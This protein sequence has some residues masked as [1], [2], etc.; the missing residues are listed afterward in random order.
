MANTFD[1]NLV[2]DVAN[3]AMLNAFAG[4]LPSTELFTTDVSA[5]GVGGHISKVAPSDDSALTEVVDGHEFGR[6]DSTLTPVTVPVKYWEKGGYITPAQIN[7]GFRIEDIIQQKADAM[8][9]GINALIT[10]EITPANFPSNGLVAATRDALSVDDV[11]E[12]EGNIEAGSKALLL[13]P[14]YYSKFTPTSTQSIGLDEG[15]YGYDKGLHKCSKFADASVV[16]FAGSKS[17]LVLATG[18]PAGSGMADRNEKVIEMPNGVEVLFATWQELNTGN[19]HFSF[20]VLAG[21]AVGL[22]DEGAVITNA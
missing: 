2:I 10:T 7:K 18:L 9:K 20:Q 15:A 11:T 13:K 19:I 1:A 16:G 4:Y 21:A 6:D 22:A 3:D 8:A 17:S 12:L 14:T 5:Q